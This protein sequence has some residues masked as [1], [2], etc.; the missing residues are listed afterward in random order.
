MLP[1]IL[2]VS[3]VLAVMWKALGFRFAVLVRAGTVVMLDR[4]QQFYRELKPGLHWIVPYYDTPH[5]VHWK[6]LT[7]ERGQD[8]YVRYESDEIE[9]TEQMFVL[10][11]T[12][13]YT[14]DNALIGIQMRVTYTVVDAQTA[15]YTM[16][17]LHQA[18]ETE[19]L[20][21][22]HD[23][24]KRVACS[25]LD[26]VAI[27]RAMKSDNGHKAW[28]PYGIQIGQCRVLD[29]VLPQRQVDASTDTVVKT[30]R[31]EADI[32][33]MELANKHAETQLQRDI[34]LVSKRA[35]LT[36]AEI[37]A[38]QSAEVAH[39]E[40]RVKRRRSELDLELEHLG[41]Y[42]Q[43]VK[44]SGL[45]P[46]FFIQYMDK[47]AL[48]RLAAAGGGGSE[49]GPSTITTIY[50]PSTLGS[51]PAG[52]TATGNAKNDAVADQTQVV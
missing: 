19:L 8:K 2:G 17:D 41:R 3:F 20:S 29:I 38:A 33:S 32:A 12:E 34:V 49:D 42:V 4:G 36:V 37:K 16:P 24:V 40:Y 15:V 48:Q 13:C 18:M 7:T 47:Q 50:V 22:L 11:F 14:Q 28:Q 30:A 10:P 45:P 9:T 23:C 52:M 31:Y 5:R 51:L 35:E 21:R 6:H 39:D 43:L 46:D 1:W 27:E 44:A 26:K 25:V